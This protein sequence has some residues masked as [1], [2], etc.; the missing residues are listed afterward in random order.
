[1]A[2]TAIPV[3]IG[4]SVVTASVPPVGRAGRRRLH[5][6]ISLTA[7]PFFSDPRLPVAG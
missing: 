4:T 6:T 1:V 5:C 7:T 2:A 3:G